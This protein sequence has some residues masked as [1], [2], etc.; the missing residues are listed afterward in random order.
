M[1]LHE[2]VMSSLTQTAEGVVIAVHACPRASKN[3]VQGLHGDAF[4]IRLRAPPVDGKANEA[5]LEFLAE[6]LD[7]PTRNLCLVSG[8]TNRQKRVLAR[9]LTVAQVQARLGV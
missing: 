7:I 2:V 1:I 9:G 4:K 8:E 3:A 6:T 5:L